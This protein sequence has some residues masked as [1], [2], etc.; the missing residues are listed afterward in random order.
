VAVAARRAPSGLARGLGIAGGLACLALAVLPWNIIRS[1]HALIDAQ[2]AVQADDCSRAVS[3]SLAA[4][5]A[6]SSRPESFELL[7][8]CDVRLGQPQLALASAAAAVRRDPQ[9]WEMHYTQALVRAVAGEDPRSAARAAL[10]RNPLDVRAQTLAQQLTFK[11]R[12][13][14]RRIALDAP[15]PLGP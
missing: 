5:R 4:T 9:N 8:W 14:W 2:R 15:L 3:R 7:A 12:R 10:R 13:D 1:Q 6:L 11:N